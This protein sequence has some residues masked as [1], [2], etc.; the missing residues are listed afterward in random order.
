MQ[1]KKRKQQKNFLD[2]LFFIL[3]VLGFVWTIA[4]W[5]T[6]QSPVQSGSA[7]SKPNNS[8]SISEKNNRTSKKKSSQNSSS[9]T[10]S[11]SSSSD[12]QLASAKQKNFAL[13]TTLSSDQPYTDY[14]YL[15][16]QGISFAY[17]RA[18]TGSSSLDNLFSSSI[19]SAKDAGLSVGAM[20]VFDSSTTA[21]GSYLYFV[22]KVGK[23]TG[24]LP[25]AIYV[26]DDS[27]TDSGSITNLQG[28]IQDLKDYYPN[29]SVIVRCDKAIYD[30]VQSQLTSLNIKYWL[31]ENN[32]DNIGSAVQF[33][34]YNANGKIGSGIRSFRL[35]ISA[36]DGSKTDLKKFSEGIEK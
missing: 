17:F 10:S 21:Y 32:L 12:T 27:I 8:R 24:N 33:V 36:F 3:V 22:Q 2:Y 31:I 11:F 20:L 26:S 34:Q 9:K 29:N 35:P 28:L 25:I 15:K 19:K 16:S 14:P 30:K 23:E 6:A 5:S 4:L 13:G 1:K 7:G 18:T